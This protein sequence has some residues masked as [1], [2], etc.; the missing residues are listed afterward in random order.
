[1]K[2][3]DVNVKDQT[4]SRDEGLDKDP[5][6]Q[7]RRSLEKSGVFPA[8]L[9]GACFTAAYL[10]DFIL[11]QHGYKSEIV[12]NNRHCFNRI[13][14]DGV[15]YI[16]DLTATQISK[17]RFDEVSFL[18]EGEAKERLTK[19]KRKFYDDD[20]VFPDSKD[21]LFPRGDE[22]LA[23]AEPL[24]NHICTLLG[25]PKMFS[26]FGDVKSLSELQEFAEKLVSRSEV[27]LEK[28]ALQPEKKKS[29]ELARRDQGWVLESSGP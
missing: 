26:E 15:P 18:E 17:E 14:K 25:E 4:M 27:F 9:T 28:K 23:V 22:S 24:V 20:L 21:L 29:K 2:G 7:I 19:F 10:S 3:N 1:M 13:Y 5:F 12:S 16:L 11:K 6:S 8:G